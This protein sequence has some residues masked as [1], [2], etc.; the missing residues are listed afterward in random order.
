MISY[1]IGWMLEG[2]LVVRGDP[3]DVDVPVLPGGP[4]QQVQVVVSPL[5][6]DMFSQVDQPAQSP[7]SGATGQQLSEL[8][9]RNYE[10]SSNLQY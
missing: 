10:L 8:F 6:S 1:N 2:N 7:Q 5:T 3:G 4:I 9:D